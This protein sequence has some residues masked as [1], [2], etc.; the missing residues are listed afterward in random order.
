MPPPPPIARDPAPDPEPERQSGPGWLGVELAAQPPPEVGVLVREVMPHSPA[1]TAG[2]TAGD[3]LISIDGQVVAGPT[4]VVRLI[5]ERSAGKRVALAFRRGAVDRLV[6]AVLAARPDQDELMRK[7]YVGSPAPQFRS[8][9][10][11]QGSVPGEVAGF[12]GKVLVVEFWASWCVPCRLSA[13]KLNAWHERWKAEG[14]EVLGVTTDP[15]TSATQ[16]A[17]DFG[18]RYS[19]ASDQ[20]GQTSRAYRAMSIPMLFVIDRAGVVR[21]VEVGYSTDGLARAERLVE[22]L[23]RTP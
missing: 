2:L 13:P 4:D 7:T 23:V 17:I 15:A 9:T 22:E 21:D 6:A 19:V 16:A 1:E 11:V 14:L 20:S 5:S 8:L 18:I 3:V 10:T 12:K